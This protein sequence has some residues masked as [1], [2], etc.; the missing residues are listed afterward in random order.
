MFENVKRDYPF[1]VVKHVSKCGK[2]ILL[3]N[4]ENI[5]R[6]ITMFPFLS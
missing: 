6:Q 2:K 4:A 1:L 3:E 5:K